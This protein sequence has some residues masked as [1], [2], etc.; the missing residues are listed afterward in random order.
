MKEQLR[1]AEVRKTRLID[2]FKK[3][4]QDFREVCFQLTGYRID[5]LADST[6]YRLTPIY[7]ENST[8]HLLFKRDDRT[9]ECSLLE[10]AFSSQLSDLIELHLAQ[11]NSIPV[12]LSAV[13]TDLFS[14]MTFQET[15]T[16]GTNDSED[17]EEE[18]DDTEDEEEVEQEEEE[19]VEDEAGGDD[20]DPICID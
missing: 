9:G 19:D 16:V 15:T 14:R 11:Q 18:R 2:A 7:A 5:G 13:T 10:T 3:T 20:D 8:D 12:F 6:T 17:E 4:S 1:L